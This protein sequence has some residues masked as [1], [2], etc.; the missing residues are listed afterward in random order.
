M[1][2]S[3]S[4]FDAVRREV[5]RLTLEELVLDGRIHPHQASKRQYE[6]NKAEVE[7][8]CGARA[9]EDSPPSEMGITDMH[10]DLVALL[11][12][13]ALPHRSYGQN[14]LRSTSDRVR[15]AWPA[16]RWPASWAST[17]S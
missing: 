14:M 2:V 16:M 7:A 11:G 10:P 6:K 8:L 9:G 5:A 3:S 13:A 15:A 17:S 4:A 1:P 12:R